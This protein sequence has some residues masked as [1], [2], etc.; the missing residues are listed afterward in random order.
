MDATK[1]IQIKEERGLWKASSYVH[2]IAKRLVRKSEPVRVRYIQEAHRILFSETNEKDAAG[3]YRR[4]DPHIERI[5][6]TEL[7]VPNWTKVPDQMAA[8]DEELKVQTFNL[9]YPATSKEYAKIIDIAIK[10]SHRLTQI[11]PF[12]NGNGRMSRL[13]INLVLARAGLPFIAIK[14]DKPA[15]LNSMLQADKC[16]IGQ[17]RRLVLKGLVEV[18]SKKVQTQ[19]DLSLSKSKK[20]KSLIPRRHDFKN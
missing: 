10:T 14:E 8:L 16:D 12:H 18:Q 11:H 2:K 1:E 6:G 3:K 13:L 19:E 9:V 17:L 7:D 15:Y 4:N 20:Q 5:D